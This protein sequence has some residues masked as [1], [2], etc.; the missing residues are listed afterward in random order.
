MARKED[1]YSVRYFRTSRAFLIP[2]QVGAQV[3]YISDGI[4]IV[5]IVVPYPTTPKALL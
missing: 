3:V 2:R 5:V 4:S 1:H